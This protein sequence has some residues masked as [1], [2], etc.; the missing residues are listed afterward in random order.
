MKY[1]NLME[2]NKQNQLIEEITKLL[3]GLSFEEIQD[4]IFEIRNRAKKNCK[5]NN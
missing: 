5:L 2:T 3:L 1:I 4:I